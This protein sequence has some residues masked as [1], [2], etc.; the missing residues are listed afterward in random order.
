MASS[1][2]SVPVFDT[3]NPCPKCGFVDEANFPVVR[4]CPGQD[5]EHEDSDQAT[6]DHLHQTCGLCGYEYLR[7]PKDRKSS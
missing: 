3:E 7:L 6:G 1:R 4:W 2:K 5:C